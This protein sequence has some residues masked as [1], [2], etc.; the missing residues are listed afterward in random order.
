MF[1]ACL[2]TSRAR[3]RTF[4]LHRNSYRWVVLT[5]SV[6]G[7]NMRYTLR[8]AMGER[9][10]A[11]V[12]VLGAGPAGSSAAGVTAAAGL[13]TV[14]I[15]RHVFPRDKVCGDAL[16]PDALDAIRELGVAEQVA[17]ASRAVEGFR[18]YAPDGTFVSLKGSCAC[19]PR[20]DFDEILRMHAVAVGAEFR[21]PL[22]VVDVL[23][24]GI[25][26]GANLEDS[27]SGAQ[28]SISAKVTILATGAPV[29]ALNR[30]RLVVRT[31]PSAVA[32]RAYFELPTSSADSLDHLIFSYDR[33]IMPGYGWIFPGPGN[34]YNVGIGCF[35]ESPSHKPDLHKVWQRFVTAFPLAKS[36]VRDARQLTPLKG[37][38]LRTSL[39]GSLLHRPG[40]LVAG[41]AA[42]TTYAFSGEGIGKAMV[43]GM[44]AGRKA[45]SLF[46]GTLGIEELGPAYELE[47]KSFA[48]RFEAYAMA[49]RWLRSARF[50][51]FLAA[52]A[53]KSSFVRGQL[54]GL[55]NE[56]SDPRTLF[57]LGGMIR[58][59]FQ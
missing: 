31:Q 34:V 10:E 33:A 27:G 48:P 46:Q 50:A 47:L 58:S 36:I 43:S 7:E 49:Q 54:E 30:L 40:L 14:L 5:V 26:H 6:Y 12:L 4:P 25:V 45:I 21:A 56:T 29:E 9:L 11:D 13:R 18:I 37:A 28:C 38:P 57:S 8:A 53:R 22:S 42:G 41:E 44:L 3:R 24:D 17:A 16:I 1:S 32:M 20:R 39:T 19:I 23:D 52:R 55:F 2:N 35:L 59:V 15:D 51:N